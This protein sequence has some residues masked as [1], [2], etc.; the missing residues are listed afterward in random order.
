MKTLEYGLA[1]V[2][3]MAQAA[4]F[5]DNR[6]AAADLEPHL[7]VSPVPSLTTGRDST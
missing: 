2:C 6:A 5:I 3:A 1:L 7:E 4:F